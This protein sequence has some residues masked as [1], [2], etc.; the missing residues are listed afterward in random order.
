[1]GY[2]YDYGLYI[3]L[4]RGN[5]AL[6]RRQGSRFLLLILYLSICSSDPWAALLVFHSQSDMERLLWGAEL[7]RSEQDYCLAKETWLFCSAPKSMVVTRRSKCGVKDYLYMN[8]ETGRE[9]SWFGE[10]ISLKGCKDD[11]SRGLTLQK[12]LRSGNCTRYYI[13]KNGDP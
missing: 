8:E 6:A 11:L 7:P 1:M 13:T 5:K 2:G 3:S 9:L 10:K 4:N 12:L